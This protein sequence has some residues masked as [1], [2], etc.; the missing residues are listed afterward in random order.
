M[1]DL[2]M[3]TLLIEGDLFGSISHGK[4]KEIKR[5]CDIAIKDGKMA[6]A[7]REQGVM[8]FHIQ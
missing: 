8:L 5:I 1:L 6:L 2:P 4:L 3:F 7:C